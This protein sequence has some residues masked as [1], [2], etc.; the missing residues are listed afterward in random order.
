MLLIL[1]FFVIPFS[2]SI[3]NQ[4]CL[5]YE[6]LTTN[7]TI[8]KQTDDMTYCLAKKNVVVLKFCSKM[9]TMFFLS[10]CKQTAKYKEIYF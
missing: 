8:A 7:V 4:F 6:F 9:S 5:I 10:Q 3:F 2:V 1:D